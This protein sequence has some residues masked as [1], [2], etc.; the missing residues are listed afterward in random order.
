MD[1]SSVFGFRI[2]QVVLSLG[3][4]GPNLHLIS[5]RKLLAAQN[6]MYYLFNKGIVAFIL[7]RTLIQILT[8]LKK[9]GKD[10]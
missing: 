4:L 5:I 6:F 8:I 1:S 9:K 2:G 3:I 7:G 10:P